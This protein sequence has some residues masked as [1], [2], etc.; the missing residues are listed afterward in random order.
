[1]ILYLIIFF[2][3]VLENALG[4]LRLIVVAD[5]RKILGAIL[6]GVISIIWILIVGAVVKNVWQNPY[7]VLFFTLGSV[8]GS[9]LG[10]FIEEKLA[11]GN[12]MVM[13]ISEDSNLANNIRDNGFGVTVTKG[14]GKDSFKNILYVIITRKNIRKLINTTKK[15]DQKALII[16]ESIKI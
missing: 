2:S 7:K 3:K 5:G 10:N 12:N 13:I 8:V 16:S 14:E 6:Q 1:M 15:Y 9:Y 4:T 11:L